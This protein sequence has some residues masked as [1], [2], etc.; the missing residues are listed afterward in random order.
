MSIRQ[1]IGMS[2]ESPIRRLKCWM[3]DREI[4]AYYEARAD[5]I[6]RIKDGHREQAILD[7]ELCQ[8]ES[9]RRFM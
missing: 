6:Q 8:L 4:K 2:M 1:L 5:V 7:R 9:R 3:L